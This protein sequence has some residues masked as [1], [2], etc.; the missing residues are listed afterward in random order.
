MKE[1]N[2]TGLNWLELEKLKDLGKGGIHYL[3]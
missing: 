3:Y 2:D 1:W